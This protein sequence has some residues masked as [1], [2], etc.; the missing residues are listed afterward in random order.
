[1]NYVVFSYQSSYSEKRRPPKYLH[2]EYILY[3]RLP[4][5]AVTTAW[6]HSLSSVLSLFMFNDGANNIS[7]LLVSIINTNADVAFILPLLNVN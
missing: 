2:S 1:M 3:S 7:L 6:L 4:S 5:S